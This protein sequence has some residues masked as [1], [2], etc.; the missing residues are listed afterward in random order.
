MYVSV[1]VYMD[2]HINEALN[3]VID[4]ASFSM[5]DKEKLSA[6]IQSNEDAHIPAWM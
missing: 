6:L 4:A 1:Y 5:S 3:V 2:I